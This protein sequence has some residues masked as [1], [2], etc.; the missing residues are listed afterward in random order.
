MSDPGVIHRSD[1][2]SC[3]WNNQ[4]H[5]LAFGT[6]STTSHFSWPFWDLSEG[7]VGGGDRS[8]LESLCVVA[9]IGEVKGREK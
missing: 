8:G 5:P 1:K 2:A 6:G 7:L 4:P 3:S 9:G